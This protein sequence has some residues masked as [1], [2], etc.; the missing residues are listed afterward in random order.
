MEQE[1]QD[2]QR[3]GDD[4]LREAVAQRVDGALDE[5]GPVVRLDDLHALGERGPE[6]CE[7]RLHPADGVARVLALA[8][9]HDRAHRLALPVELREAATDV[10]AEAH[11]ADVLDAE[12]RPVRAG[13]DRGL[14]ELAEILEVAA[15]AHEV[16]APAHLEEP[17]A[18]LAV[19]AADGLRDLP[20]P[21]AVRAEL[22]G[23]ERDLV[24]P[25]VPA[26]RGDLGDARH[27]LEAV[28]Q[29]EVLQG[30]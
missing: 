12:R 1:Q 19:R 20:D 25:L 15:S 10:G 29:G 7:A 18:D 8:H 3:D 26:D 14:A 16:L 22:L 17:A 30:A 27:A 11:R 28:A 23:V 9:D 4:L 21:E 5:G 24:L 13:P 6:L 2:D